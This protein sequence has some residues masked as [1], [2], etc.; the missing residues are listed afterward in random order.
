MCYEPIAPNPIALT[1]GPFAP[2][3]LVGYVA[4]DGIVRRA[5]ELDRE[6][7]LNAIN[8]APLIRP[9]ISARMK[10]CRDTHFVDGTGCGFVTI[11]TPHIILGGDVGGVRKALYL[12]EKESGLSDT[13]RLITL[14]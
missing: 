10:I 12:E 6:L 11:F 14:A 1:V 9:P 7:S 4:A 2:N 13:G 3:F 5:E 8:D